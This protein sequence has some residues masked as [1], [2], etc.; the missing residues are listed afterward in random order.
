MNQNEYDAVRAKIQAEYDAVVDRAKEQL[1]ADIAALD[2]VWLL[3]GD[4]ASTRQRDNTVDQRVIN[5][6]SPK[7]TAQ[8]VRSAIEI[9]VIEIWEP[10]TLFD[11]R[12]VMKVIKSDFEGVPCNKHTVGQKLRYM[13]RDGFLA[14]AKKGTGST[15]NMYKFVPPASSLKKKGG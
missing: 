8:S 6:D 2:R 1:T 15:S 5:L 7:R 9:I 3:S 12:D 14:L 13:E 11:W 4:G 10:N